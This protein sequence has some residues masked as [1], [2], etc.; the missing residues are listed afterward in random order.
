MELAKVNLNI[1]TERVNRLLGTRHDIS[2]M[3]KV[4]QGSAGSSA[5]QKVT[6][7]EIAKMLQEAADSAKLAS[8]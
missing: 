3:A 7:D 1:L 8:A 2:Y 4:R 6:N 5:L